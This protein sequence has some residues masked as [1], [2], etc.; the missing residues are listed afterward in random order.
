[1]PWLKLP[2]YKRREFRK[3]PDD[4]QISAET[5]KQDANGHMVI[6]VFRTVSARGH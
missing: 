4:S 2:P 1:L 3:A 6:G 5:F